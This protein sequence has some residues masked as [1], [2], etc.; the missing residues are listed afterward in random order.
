MPI[1]CYTCPSCLMD[2]AIIYEIYKPLSKFAELELCPNCESQMSLTIPRA[3]ATHIFKAD[4]WDID[5]NPVWI[6]SKKQLKE[7]CQ[8][9]DLIATGYM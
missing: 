8:K 7:E 9:R 3:Q 4:Y 2:G 5:V 6:E 1:Y